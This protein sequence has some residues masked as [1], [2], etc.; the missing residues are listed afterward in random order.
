MEDVNTMYQRYINSQ[1]TF[2]LVN[3]QYT[4]NHLPEVWTYRKTSNQ[5]CYNF[6]MG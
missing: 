4:S 6:L 5:R 3:T 1:I 2:S